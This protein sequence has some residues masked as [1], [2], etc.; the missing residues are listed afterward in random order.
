MTIMWKVYL[1]FKT[2]SNR[3]ALSDQLQVWLS[4][5]SAILCLFDIELNICYF[6]TK[7]DY[8]RA[9]ILWIKTVLDMLRSNKS[10]QF[11]RFSESIVCT[12]VRIV[13]TRIDY[14]LAHLSRMLIGEFVV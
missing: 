6:Q 13:I 10:D 11:C 7:V 14:F 4:A 2:F 9:D 8:D 5:R 1:V 12:S 3:N